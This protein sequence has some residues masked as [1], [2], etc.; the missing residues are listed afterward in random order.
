MVESTQA[1]QPG[2]TWSGLLFPKVSLIL[3]ISIGLA[4]NMT[5]A[6]VF[7]KCERFLHWYTTGK[8]VVNQCDLSH[9]FE[10]T[11]HAD[12]HKATTIYFSV[13]QAEL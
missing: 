13:A 9:V 7:D 1:G 5:F 4:E 3:V 2:I 12:K 10:H 11:I 8:S 6:P